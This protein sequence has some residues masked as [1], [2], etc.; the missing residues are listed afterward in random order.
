MKKRFLALT[1][2]LTMAMGMTMT[3]F[4]A[5]DSSEYT[6][7]S[8]KDNDAD[9]TVEVDYTVDQEYKVTIPADVTFGESL[10]ATKEVKA[11][12]VLIDD[13]NA[14][15]VKMTSTN[16]TEATGYQLLYKDSSIVYTITKD[17][18]NVENASNIL[19]VKP[20]EGLVDGSGKANG[21]TELVLATDTDKIALAQKAGKHV[22]TLTFTV[23]VDTAQ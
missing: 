3:A 10:T 14:L 17:N 21:S 4:A 6:Q 5:T 15:Y 2:A 23:S 12:D 7:Q 16:Y 9:P 8:K 20:G 13:G 22:D 19:I 11:E 18:E 1:L